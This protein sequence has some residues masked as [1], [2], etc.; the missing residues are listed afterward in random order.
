MSLIKCP[1]CGKEVSET[2]DT[3]IHCGYKLKKDAP[4]GKEIICYRGQ[5]NALAPFGVFD[6]I[7]GGIIALI[8]LAFL[9]GGIVM[10]SNGAEGSP[11]VV[12]GIM[13]IALA[14][15]AIIAGAFAFVKIK[16]NQ[17][18]KEDCIVYD[19]ERDLLLLTDYN[20][21]HYEVKPSQYRQLRR[22]ISTDFVL[23]F[24]YVDDNQRMKKL[25]LGFTVETAQAVIRLQELSR[26]N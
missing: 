16:R 2:C 10:I 14:V 8:G 7:A 4:K 12:V 23:V 15:F 3:C 13:F 11:L 1:E 25:K 19:T 17:A 6:L 24:Y 20:G 5:G 22:T 26:K 21:K 18:V 9:I